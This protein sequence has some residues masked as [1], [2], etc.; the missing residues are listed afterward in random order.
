LQITRR[1]KRSIDGQG[2]RER[3]SVR[4][5][6]THAEDGCGLSPSH[7]KTNRMTTYDEGAMQA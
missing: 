7:E 2:L 5:V 3:R 6:I 4:H 1:N